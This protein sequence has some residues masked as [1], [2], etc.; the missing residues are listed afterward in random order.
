MRRWRLVLVVKLAYRKIGLHKIGESTDHQSTYYNLIFFI[1]GTNLT[2][3]ISFIQ[4]NYLLI[5]PVFW[6]G[7]LGVGEVGQ[8][9]RQDREV[10]RHKGDDCQNDELQPILNWPHYD[11][12]HQHHH[13]H[14][15]HHHH[16][17]RR[18]CCH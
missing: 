8:G 1:T 13:N 15:H 17:H 10:T 2:T 12:H 11:Q 16:N 5:L 4:P 7:G 18:C 9:R 14:H 3:S 6:E